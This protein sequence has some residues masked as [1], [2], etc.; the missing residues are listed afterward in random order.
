MKRIGVIGCGGRIRCV[1]KNIPGL[2]SD[3]VIAAIYDPSEVSLRAIREEFS[4]R[5]CTV[6][7]SWQE[8]V[9]LPELDW[10][11]VGSWNCAH[12]E[13]V[14]GAFTAGKHVFCEKPLATTEA[15]CLAVLRAWRASGRLFTIGFTLRY[16]PHYRKIKELLTQGAIGQLISMEFNETIGFN[17][18]GYIHGNWRR[19]RENAG[20]HLLEKCCHD[21]DLVN[22]FVGSPA[23][24]V[25]SFGG[26][27][28]F[29]PANRHHQDRIGPSPKG[30]IAY[31]EW[32]DPWRQ[33]PFTSNKDIYDNQVAI[34]E[35]ANHVRATFHTN[36]NCALPERRMYLCGTEGT[37]RADVISGRLEV[38][39]IGWQYD[40]QIIPPAAQGGHGGGDEVLGPS[41]AA[42]ILRD[43][44]PFTGVEDGLRSAFTAYALD[45]AA[46]EGRVVDLTDI[47]RRAEL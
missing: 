45:Q 26:C 7:E 20:T 44:P 40:T 34:L 43:E 4:L 15:D 17:H 8:L 2:G 46:D 32:P 10:V 41:L 36:C 23:Q 47:W 33:N 38:S 42:S 1:L 27:D 37:L 9:A 31:E 18:G 24:R 16:S 14:I 19:L 12:A 35:F 29:T 25:A 39:R 11:F 5:D 13:Q 28:F 6:C 21:I 22:W 3:I 30:A